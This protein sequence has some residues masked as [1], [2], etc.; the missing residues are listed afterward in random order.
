MRH[1]ARHGIK[2]YVLRDIPGLDGALLVVDEEI[3]A[4]RVAPVILPHPVQNLLVCEYNILYIIQMNIIIIY[5][6]E[7]SSHYISYWKLFWQIGYRRDTLL[8][9]VPNS[10][11]TS[12]GS[13]S[14][15][16]KG[17]YAFK[18]DLLNVEAN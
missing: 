10:C 1:N 11:W 15:H 17:I 4:F 2:L 7:L 8:K 12:R 5:R 16:L 13:N 18:H 3:T 14:H 6:F 9:G